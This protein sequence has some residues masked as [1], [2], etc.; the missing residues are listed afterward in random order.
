MG[1]PYYI[2]DYSATTVVSAGKVCNDVT[3]YECY[4]TLTDGVYILRLGG[5]LFGRL[6]GTF[7]SHVFALVY[8]IIIMTDFPHSD[9]KWSGCGRNGT[10][11]DQFVFAIA[12]GVCTPVQVFR[13]TSRCVQPPPVNEDYYSSTAT[14]TKGGTVAPTQSTFG[15][16]YRAGL[17]S[18][19]I[20]GVNL[21]N[22]D[23]V[24]PVITDTM[25]TMR[26]LK[27]EEEKKNEARKLKETPQKLYSADRNKKRR[28]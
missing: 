13:Y 25:T 12:K 5:G 7:N 16:P 24:E 3:F 14:P 1:A 8:I 26:R 17:Y 28:K 15:N 23:Y 2:S 4:Q 21:N 27:E 20:D 6:T 18:I 19:E 9:A 22:D 10:Y 11:L